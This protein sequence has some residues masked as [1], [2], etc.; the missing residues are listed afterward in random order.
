MAAAYKAGTHRAQMDLHEQEGLFD[1]SSF[2][3]LAIVDSRGSWDG[4]PL[5]G[6]A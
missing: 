6:R 2:T 3:R 5:A 1:R 4:D